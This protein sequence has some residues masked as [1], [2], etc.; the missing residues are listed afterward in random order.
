VVLSL[1]WMPRESRLRCG[2]VLCWQRKKEEDFGIARLCWEGGMDG[3]SVFQCVGWAGRMYLR[4]VRAGAGCTHDKKVDL[5]T[6]ASPS[7]S[8]V[9]SGGRGK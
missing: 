1:G 6:S 5:P 2:R 7:S 9:T 3:W 4:D 8:T